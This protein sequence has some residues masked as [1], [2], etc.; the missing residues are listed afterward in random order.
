MKY[1]IYR[2]RWTEPEGGRRLCGEQTGWCDRAAVVNQWRHTG[3][4]NLWSSDDE[5]HCA[6]CGPGQ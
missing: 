5:W 6:G 4:D 2:K 1:N 3:A